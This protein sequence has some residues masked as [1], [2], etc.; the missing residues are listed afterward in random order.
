MYCCM[1][2][3][4]PDDFISVN[5]ELT[6]EPLQN[7]VCVNVTI[8]NDEVVE[9]TESFFAVIKPEKMHSH[10]DL[11]PRTSTEFFIINDDS[12]F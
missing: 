11:D 5:Q 10:I 8:V 3:D 12:E 9:L 1:V 7:R 4:S 2:T 6:F